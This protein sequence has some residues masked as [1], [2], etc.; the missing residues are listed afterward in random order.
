MNGHRLP[1][2]PPALEALYGRGPGAAPLYLHPNERAIVT[3]ARAEGLAALEDV[4]AG[5]H[6]A[7]ACMERAT[8]GRPL[9]DWMVGMLRW[10]R[11]HYKR[12]GARVLDAW[13][14]RGAGELF[15]RAR[16]AGA[17]SAEAVTPRAAM[18]NRSRRDRTGE[19]L[20]ADVGPLWAGSSSATAGGGA[21]RAADSRPGAHHNIQGPKSL[22]GGNF[23]EFPK[24]AEKADPRGGSVG[25]TRAGQSGFTSSPMGQGPNAEPTPHTLHDAKPPASPES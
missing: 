8:T 15:R 14:D 24:F 18:P 19:R 21:S 1:G 6:Y 23:S 25:S 20:E 9:P 22:T 12:A 16:A 2:M 3:H 13:H 4:I 11:I 10:A 17:A 7:V 5:G